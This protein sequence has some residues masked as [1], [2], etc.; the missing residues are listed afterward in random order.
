ML[1]ERVSVNGLDG[2]QLGLFDPEDRDQ[3]PLPF[4]GND[5]HLFPSCVSAMTDG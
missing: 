5:Q 1:V 2:L 3:S 4:V